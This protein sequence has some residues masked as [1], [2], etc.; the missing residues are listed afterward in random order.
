M[1]VVKLG[2]SL[3]DS[4]TLCDRLAE[5]ATLPGPGRIVVPGGG[6]FA[7]VVRHLQQSLGYDDLAAHRMAILAMQQFGLALHALEP[8][9]SLA[10]S[11]P[12]L[13]AARAAIWLPWRL[14]G[15][16]PEIAASWDVTSDSLAC[17][18]ATRVGASRLVLV[19]SASDL[20]GDPEVWA[21]S[22]LVDQAFPRHA[23]RF[24]G[25]ITIRH[26]DEP[27]GLS[28]S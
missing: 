9:L 4:P 23:A 26:R 28:G 15:L 6:P 22:G 10:E 21:K 19:K 25:T 7:D 3:H 27:L 5:L 11:D 2:G 17:W 20:A 8:R 24:A 1:W 12:E 13:R 14:A 18:L 16:A